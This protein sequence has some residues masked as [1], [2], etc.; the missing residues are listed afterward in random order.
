MVVVSAEK[1]IKHFS[2]PLRDLRFLLCSMAGA[3]HSLRP[4]QKEKLL[5]L[6]LRSCDLLDDITHINK[7]KTLKVLEISGDSHLVSI[8][9]KLFDGMTNLQ[10][11]NLSRL[12][13]SGASALKSM[14]INLF[15]EITNL[16]SLNLSGLQMKTL[17]SFSKLSELRVLILKGC[18]RL[19]K[20][21]SLRGLEGALAW[22][23]CKAFEDLKNFRYLISLMLPLL[24]GLTTQ[25]YR[26]FQKFK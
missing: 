5:V 20:L 19:E 7:L 6:V 10:S 26:C 25:L 4:C 1:S 16:Q 23:N 17:P 12:D 3:N 8:P 2:T 24:K 14:P 15:D 9:D 21:Q 11:L 13:I 22:R 18:S